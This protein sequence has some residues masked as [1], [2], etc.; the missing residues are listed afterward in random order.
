MRWLDEL[1]RVSASA[2]TAVAARRQRG[3]G[4]VDRTAAAARHPDPGAAFAAVTG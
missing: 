1:Q 4:N 3:H 2:K